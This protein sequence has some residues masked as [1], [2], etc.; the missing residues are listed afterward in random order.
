MSITTIFILIGTAWL[1]LTFLFKDQISSFYDKFKGLN[2][3]QRNY[4]KKIVIKIPG[5]I[6]IGMGIGMDIYFRYQE[7]PNV[8]AI[9]KNT[10]WNAILGWLAIGYGILTLLV[11]LFHKEEQFFSK[12][13]AIKEAHGKERGA[14]KH[15]MAYTVTPIIFGLLLL[16]GIIE[17]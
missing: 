8:V 6:F 12:Y 15:I 9:I 3:K 10:N 16:L 1:F 13:N 11:R 14:L 5:I 2:E 4:Y 17:L 7:N